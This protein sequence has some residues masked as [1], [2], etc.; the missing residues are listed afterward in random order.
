MIQIHLFAARTHRVVSSEVKYQ[1][2]KHLRKVYI[3]DRI[4]NIVKMVMKLVEHGA[5]INA[6]NAA[7]ETPFSLLKAKGLLQHLTVQRDLGGLEETE[8]EVV[9]TEE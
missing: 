9:P 7:G 5:D 2:L 6:K 8:E 4:F 3:A 1:H